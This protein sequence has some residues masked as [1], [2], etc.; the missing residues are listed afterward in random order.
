MDAVQAFKTAIGEGQRSV[1]GLLHPVV[2]ACHV[3]ATAGSPRG[4]RGLLCA[5]FFLLDGKIEQLDVLRGKA[6][7]DPGNLFFVV[8]L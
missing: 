6:P 3:T 1:L 4:Q 8:N 2:E 5:D 7:T